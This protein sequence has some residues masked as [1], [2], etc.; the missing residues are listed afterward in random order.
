MPEQP[1]LPDDLAQYA[2]PQASAQLPDDLAQYQAKG[3]VPFAPAQKLQ[4][5]VNKYPESFKNS[6][7]ARTARGEKPFENGQ[8][9]MQEPGESAEDFYARAVSAGKQVTPEQIQAEHAANKKKLPYVLAAAPVMGAALPA[10]EVGT[11]EYGPAVAQY[12]GRQAVNVAK[13]IPTM[14]AMYGISKARQ[15]P[16]VG[17]M[18]PPGAE[19]LPMFLGGKGGA[20]PAA[21]GEFTLTPPEPEPVNPANAEPP[22]PVSTLKGEQL[23]LAEQPEP[24]RLT[25]P[26]EPPPRTIEGEQEKLLFEKEGPAMSRERTSPT[27]KANQ[28]VRK[29]GPAIEESFGVK[30]TEPNEPIYQPKSEATAMSPPPKPAGTALPEGHTPV[31]S[32]AIKSYRYDRASRTMEIQTKD[33]GIHRYGE[34]EPEEYNKFLDTKSKGQAFQKIKADHVHLASKYPGRDWVNKAA[35]RNSGL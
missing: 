14:A 17:K 10:A 34:V 24:F 26:P 32:T 15:I 2:K 8:Y 3:P 1:Q 20:A 11:A 4:E 7:Q 28:A 16:V 29:Y 9:L 25:P 22:V 21:E 6:A 18:I 5:E 33:G 30:P 19:W 23:P 12:A 31:E 27:A 35:P 13:A